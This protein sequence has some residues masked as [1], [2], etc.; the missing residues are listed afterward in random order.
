M[1]RTLVKPSHI[2]YNKQKGQFK[3]TLVFFLW[4]VVITPCLSHVSQMGFQRLVKLSRN[5]AENTTERLLGE[6]M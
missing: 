4:I 6:A 3:I 2:K 1:Y 5:N